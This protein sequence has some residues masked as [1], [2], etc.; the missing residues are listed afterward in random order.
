[1][2]ESGVKRAK[3]NSEIGSDSGDTK[4]NNGGEGEIGDARTK[5]KSNSAGK[6]G[7]VSGGGTPAGPRAASTE[8]VE[9]E[10]KEAEEEEAAPTVEEM[11]LLDRRMRDQEAAALRDNVETVAASFKGQST[12]ELRG[13]CQSLEI[14][15]K[16]S[17]NA[18][19]KRLAGTLRERFQLET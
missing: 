17:R 5:A 2:S 9:E 3:S 13:W 6:G 4:S 14:S 7:E 15:N 11:I 8:P 18:V 16:G 12:I 1:M 10:D 19:L